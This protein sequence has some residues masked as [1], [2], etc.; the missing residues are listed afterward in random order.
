MAEITLSPQEAGNT[1]TRV[2]DQLKEYQITITQVSDALVDLSNTTFST[3]IGAAMQLLA[4]GLNKIGYGVTAAIGRYS[5]SFSEVVEKLRQ[6]YATEGTTV[7]FETPSFNGVEYHDHPDQT[8]RVDIGKVEAFLSDLDG[9][10]NKLMTIFDQIAQEYRGSA[11]YWQSEGGERSRQT[12]VS[13]I[14]PLNQDVSEDINKMRNILL[15]ELNNFKNA[16][17]SAVE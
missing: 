2:N 12:F 10:R 9:Y 16:M 3:P 15:D 7:S 8:I 6:V 1:L 4:S 17:Q 14:E 5:E 13:K 11:S